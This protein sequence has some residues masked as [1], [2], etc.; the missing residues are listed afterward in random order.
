MNKKTRALTLS[1]LFAALT[2]ISLYI[3]SVWPTG[4]IGLAAA[5]SIFVVAAIVE[6]GI[7]SGVS[8]FIV[9]SLLGMLLLPNRAA[10]LLYMLFFGYYPV[11][12]SFIERLSSRPLQLVLKLCVFNLA[13]TAL[14]FLFG[15]LIFDFGEFQPSPILLYIA[16][17]VLFAIFDYGFTKVIWLYINRISKYIQKGS[18]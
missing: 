2:V 7:G 17:S 5:A 4:T 11:V 13:L 10:P 9:S 15:E 8:V 6:A 12:K 18:G 3:A 1:A 14:W 16:G